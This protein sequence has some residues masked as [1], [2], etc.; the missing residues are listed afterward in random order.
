MVGLALFGVL[1][2]RRR[3]ELS[4]T[5]PSTIMHCLRLRPRVYKVKRGNRDGPW[6][7]DPAEGT[8]DYLAVDGDKRHSTKSHARLSSTETISVAAL[9]DHAKSLGL[10]LKTRMAR[11]LRDLPDQFSFPWRDR[12][13]EVPS[14]PHGRNFRVDSWDASTS[15]PSTVSGAHSRNAPTEYGSGAGNSRT[16]QDAILEED[17][18][19]VE[20][21]LI[22]PVDRD[23]NDVFLIGHQPGN[24]TLESGSSNSKPRSV[25][26][27]PPTP[28]ASYTGSL[29]H[30]TLPPTVSVLLDALCLL[31]LIFPLLYRC[32]RIVCTYP[33]HLHC[34]HPYPLHLLTAFYLSPKDLLQIYTKAN[35]LPRDP[36][37]PASCRPTSPTLLYSITVPLKVLCE[38]P[39]TFNMRLL[40]SPL[41]A[42]AARYP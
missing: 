25:Q 6:S 35:P 7:I 19:N 22:S 29:I 20:T 17:E 26:V 3:S 4:Q 39:Y 38:V 32:C 34:Q 16:H 18:E 2:Y 27:I 42:L 21:S 31:I 23:E 10:P 40:G 33:P 1:F 30:P 36:Y 8:E 15:S 13:V 12:P 5:W 24:F 11:R 37:R 28:T 9:S 41:P 14:K